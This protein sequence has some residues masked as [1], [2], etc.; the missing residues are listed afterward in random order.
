M[1]PVVAAFDVDGTLTV[2]DCVFPFLWR[3]GGVRGLVRSMSRPVSLLGAV[4]RRDRD[5][6]KRHFVRSFLSGEGAEHVRLNGETFARDVASSWMRDDVAQ[7]LRWHQDQGHVVLL[8]SASLDAYLDP[9]GDLLEVDAV[10]CTRLAVSD[11]NLT[12]EIEG[13]NCRA[14]EKVARL[15]QWATDSGVSG[16]GWLAYAYGDSSGDTEM[17]GMSLNASNVR[18][19]EVTS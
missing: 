9:L 8:V 13:E 17:L 4:V 12:G 11:G 5:F 14:A 16:D 6:L 2:R 3:V 1:E 10:L 19:S 15:R 18:H 7:R